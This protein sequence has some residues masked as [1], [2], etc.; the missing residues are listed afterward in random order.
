MTP[1]EHIETL[2]QLQTEAR[3]SVAHKIDFLDTLGL[4]TAF[5]QEEEQVAGSV[6]CCLP[7]IASLID[8][9]VVRLKVGGRLIYV[10]AGNSGRVGF[11]DSSEL[12]V[13][14]SAD[15]SQFL[16]VVAG[17]TEAII[18]AREGAED[19]ETDGVAKLEALQLTSKDTVIGISASG[20]TPFVLGALKVAL[21]R[22]AL[23]AGI[24]NAQPSSIDDLG[25]KYTICALVGPEFLAGSTRLKAGGAA[26]QILNMIS[27]C[28][29]VKLG[30]TYKGLM[31][32]V[33]VKNDKLKARAR[34]IVRQVCEGTP[35]H[36]LDDTNGTQSTRVLKNSE[37]SEADPALDQLIE[38]C[39]GSVK[40]AC[41]VATSGLNPD[42]ARH[43]L[44]LANDKF[45][46][47]VERL[48]NQASPQGLYTP[49]NSEYFLCVDGGGTKCTVSIATRSKVVGKGTA[50]ACNFNCVTLED[51]LTQIKLATYQSWSCVSKTYGLGMA[52][53]PRFTRVW[54]GL[55]GLYHAADQVETLIQRLEELFGVSFHHGTLRLTSDDM[56]LSSGIVTDNSVETG[57]SVIAGTGSVATAFKRDSRG[58]IIQL[59]RTGGWGYLLGDHGSAFDIGK[60]AL[61]TVL[62]GIEQSQFD[63]ARKTSELESRILARLNCTK[64]EV[65]SNVFGAGSQP[66]R[67]ISD[68]ANV[69]TAL[70]F[71]KDN[72]DS[73]ALA[74]LKSAAGSLI[75]LIKPLCKAGLCDPSRSALILSGALMGLSSYQ[76]LILKNWSEQQLEPFKKVVVVDDVSSYAAQILAKQSVAVQE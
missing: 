39:G 11:M 40:L 32:D 54:V 65:L 42:L 18:Q 53:I 41:A 9:L 27:T 5:N 21:R 28:T 10:G 22:D 57:V 51:I 37:T 3:N 14:F 44:Q 50:G 71:R 34:R 64:R 58:E 31:I 33:R 8:D 23:T 46:I 24:T 45:H 47:F 76:D 59:G 36:V 43:Q 16:A 62:A 6:A 19:S 17:G 69:V 68:L 55:A 75:D 38:Q 63:D 49:K 67:Q 15:P 66:K 26:K 12:P 35:I 1:S 61:Q 7:I 4:C 56:L 48:R 29:M 20:R 13:T 25:V 52:D 70:G 73:Q 2:G 30:K 72:P 60:R 74:I